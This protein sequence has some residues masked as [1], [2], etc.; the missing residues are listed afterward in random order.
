MAKAAPSWGLFHSL[1]SVL[2][3]RKIL[4]LAIF[5]A[6]PES[7]EENETA[8]EADADKVVAISESSTVAPTKK[9]TKKK[10]EGGIIGLVSD[11]LDDDD[12]DDDKKTAEGT[13]PSKDDNEVDDDDEGSHIH[14]IR[15]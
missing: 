2:R 7:A 9:P 13:T 12:D 15:Q 1:H 6:K 3:T 10:E 11:L 4:K 5:Q 14:Q 8:A